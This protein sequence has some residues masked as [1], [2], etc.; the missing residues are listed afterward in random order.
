MTWKVRGLS[1]NHT[2]EP[3]STPMARESINSMSI[4]LLCRDT[5]FHCTLSPWLAVQAQGL[6]GEGNQHQDGRTDDQRIDANVEQQ[7][8]RQMHDTEHGDMQ[9]NRNRGQEGLGGPPHA[10]RGGAGSQQAEGDPVL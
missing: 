10:H 3:A 9:I 5:S 2:P 6:V 4:L 7:Y 1:I 8:R